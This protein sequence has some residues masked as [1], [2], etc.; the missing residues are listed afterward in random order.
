MEAGGLCIC[1][2]RTAGSSRL[3]SAM[4]SFEVAILARAAMTGRKREQVEDV[5]L[6]SLCMNT[7]IERQTLLLHF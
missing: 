2:E 3:Q 7:D 6:F 4:V 5:K 1:Y